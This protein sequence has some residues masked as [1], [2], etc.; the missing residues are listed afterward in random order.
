MRAVY[1][2]AE[3]P[4][5]ADERQGDH[6]GPSGG[7]DEPKHQSIPAATAAAVRATQ[8]SVTARNSATGRTR[9][10]RVMAVFLLSGDGSDRLGV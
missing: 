4:G 3:E 7:E 9:A 2:V 1:G 8:A 5:G 10:R 6:G